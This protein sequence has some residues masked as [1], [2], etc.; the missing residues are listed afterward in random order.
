MLHELT[1][2]QQVIGLRPQ[3]LIPHWAACPPGQLRPLL[4]TD[5]W[6]PGW[7]RCCQPQEKR[8]VASST[9]ELTGPEPTEVAWPQRELGSA[10]LPCLCPA[11][12]GSRVLSGQ[13]LSSRLGNL[14]PLQAN[15]GHFIWVHCLSV[16]PRSLEELAG[17]SSDEVASWMA[18]WPPVP[19]RP[20]VESLGSQ[21]PSRHSEQCTL[22]SPISFPF[23][24]R[25]AAG[26][27]SLGVQS[28]RAGAWTALK[29]L[30]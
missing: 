30:S 29:G 16:D 11:G 13:C 18:G 4:R 10:A 28:L 23:L 15:S 9:R 3:R 12:W 22:S 27:G 17:V 1:Y 14:V 19:T 6:D 2:P 21:N 7:H 26:C 8:G 20:A 24:P 5:H 25:W